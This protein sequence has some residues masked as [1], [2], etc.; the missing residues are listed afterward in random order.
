MKLARATFAAVA[1]L[2]GLGAPAV[3]QTT[4]TLS[5]PQAE[6][7]EPFTQVS[8]VR[9]LP[10]GKV[11][12]ADIRDKIVQM[13]D[14]ATGDAVKVGREGQG[15]GEY[16]L[17]V[18]LLAMPGNKTWVVD[19]M[20]RRFLEVTPDGKPAETVP[21]FNTGGSRMIMVGRN[22]GVDAKGRLYFQAS[23]FQIGAGGSINTAESPDSLAIQRWV[24]GQ[25]SLDTVA[26]IRPP[27]SNVS[28][29][30]SGGGRQ[31]MVRIGGSK[32]YT[33]QEA[34]GVDASGR[35]ARVTPEPYR[36]IWYDGARARS[37][38]TIPYTPIRVTDADKK[39][40]TEA[41]RSSAP[42][43]VS[44]SAGGG[45]NRSSGGPVP[46][47]GL[48]APEFEETK[49]AFSGAQVAPNGEVW[50]ARN[51][52]AGDDKPLYDVFDGAGKLVRQVRLAP[53]SSVVGFGNGTVYVVRR[54]EDDLQ[55]LQR[56]AH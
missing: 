51:R 25:E 54:D 11:L 19:M 38:Q 6:F 1:G 23:P 26:W 21:M 10:G 17:P 46:A 53:R 16:A 41:Q 9:E 49:P 31:V 20:G 8:G 30:P 28:S 42:I 37:G 52:P 47:N 15:P 45:A 27:K 2:L 44:F 55:Y 32:V 22:T 3:A 34:W 5:K 40:Y 4:V 43:A 24:P 33:P 12:V 7:P 29:T 56:F 50:V 48:P 39:A 35:V 14:L 13:V 36:V 18:D